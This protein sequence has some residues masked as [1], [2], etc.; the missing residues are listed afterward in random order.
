MGYDTVIVKKEEHIA[1]VIMNRSHRM[2]ALIPEM[3]QELKDALQDVSDDDDIRVVILT[4]AGKGFCT[5]SDMKEG[6]A[7]GKGAQSE[8]TVDELRRHI[9]H[10]PQQITLIIRNMEKPVIAM[11]NGPAVADGFDWA[12]AC[13]LRV[14]CENTRFMNAFVKMALFPNTGETWLLPR[15]IGVGKAL[16]IMLTGDLLEAEEAYRLGVLNK[17]VPA[18]DLESETM[19]LAR[20][21]A[22]QSPVSLRLLKMQTYRGLEMG[23][24]TALELAADGEAMTMKTEDY[25]EA[26]NAFREKRQP[27][28]KGK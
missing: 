6:T 12:L 2:N 25:Q 11:V 27:D 13:D 20:K 14:G 17:L 5:G 3:F 7:S 28:F 18:V 8:K 16:E 23:L 15:I 1:T 22:R 26:L 4:G 19:A 21:L 10:N 9:H 24:E